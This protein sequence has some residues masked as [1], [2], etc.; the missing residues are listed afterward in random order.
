MEK[1]R[2]KYNF[3]FFPISLLF[4]IQKGMPQISSSSSRSR[5]NVC[6][7]STFLVLSTKKKKKKTMTFT[8]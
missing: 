4:A 3:D 7:L 1:R 5:R 6:R 8:V 2:E